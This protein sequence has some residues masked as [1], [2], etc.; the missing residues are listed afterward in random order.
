MWGMA[1]STLEKVSQRARCPVMIVTMETR[2]PGTSRTSCRHGPF[3]AGRVRRGLRGQLAR[4]LQ[5]RAHGV[6]SSWSRPGGRTE[7]ASP[8]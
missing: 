4:A 2:G 5:G 6:Q 7:G 3:R 1:G 8:G